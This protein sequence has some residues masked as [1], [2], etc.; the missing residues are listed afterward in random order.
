MTS[1]NEFVETHFFDT[2]M[3]GE[4]DCSL[5]LTIIYRTGT[6]QRG[7][8]FALYLQA[9]KAGNIQAAR[10]KAQGSPYLIAG[11]E[12]LCRQLQGRAIT[13]P[14]PN[15]QVLAQQMDLPKNQQSVVLLIEEGCAHALKL[16][17][18]AGVY[19]E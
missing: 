16:L 3:T 15:N 2:Q 13:A 10:F 5:P 12:W 1:Y 11:L 6:V 4:L 7:L 18:A 17:K 8:L 9:D 14:F 19:Y